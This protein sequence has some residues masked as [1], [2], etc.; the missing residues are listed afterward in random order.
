MG[1][2]RLRIQAGAVAELREIDHWK[3]TESLCVSDFLTWF[4]ELHRSEFCESR[5]CNTDS[6][7]GG[8]IQDGDG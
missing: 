2:R 3:R 4:E 1:S 7:I 8:E 6:W 5:S